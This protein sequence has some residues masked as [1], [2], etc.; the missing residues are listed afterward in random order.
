MP[1]KARTKAMPPTLLSI[2]LVVAGLYF[3]RDVLIPI[4]LAV[5]LSFLLAPAVAR[6]Q[7]AGMR[8]AMAV[9]IVMFLARSA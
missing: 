9:G 5:L 4:A 8:R 1:T 7:R 6:L 3:A 2:A